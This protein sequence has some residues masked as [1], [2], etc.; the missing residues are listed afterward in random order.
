MARIRAALRHTGRG[1]RAKARVIEA[2]GLVVD[3]L[4]RIVTRDGEP[5]RLTPK[6]I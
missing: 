5:V 3:T 4:R 6:G 2:G 1:G